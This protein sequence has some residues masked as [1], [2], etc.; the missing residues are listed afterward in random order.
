MGDRLVVS[1][2]SED[3]KLFIANREGATRHEIQ[4]QFEPICLAAST[5]AAA[6]GGDGPVCLVGVEAGDITAT[7][8]VSSNSQCLAFDEQGTRLACGLASGLLLF[9][10]A[11][12]K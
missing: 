5:T 6:V 11:H 10:V 3:W 4:L 9:T 12:S 8:P 1:C 7:L 2:G